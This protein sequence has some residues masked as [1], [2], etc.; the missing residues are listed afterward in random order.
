MTEPPQSVET[1]LAIIN[2]KLDVLI[3]TRD[4]HELRLRKLEQFKWVL[5]GVAAASGGVAQAVA[6]H[7]T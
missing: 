1:Q 5:L 2:T 4:D 6:S 7:L 3:A